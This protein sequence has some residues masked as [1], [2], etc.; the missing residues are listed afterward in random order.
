MAQSLCYNRKKTYEVWYKCKLIDQSF[1]LE[2]YN[3]E[4]GANNSDRKLLK[5]NFLFFCDG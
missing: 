2:M 5:I 3:W 1:S 4:W